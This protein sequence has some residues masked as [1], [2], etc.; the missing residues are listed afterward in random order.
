[1]RFLPCETSDSFKTFSDE[2]RAAQG[3][4]SSMKEEKAIFHGY[5]FASLLQ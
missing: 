1:V 3:S 2:A 5:Y 4:T